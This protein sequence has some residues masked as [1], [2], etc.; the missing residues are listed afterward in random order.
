MIGSGKKVSS[1]GPQG[2][3]LSQAAI[4]A[5]YPWITLRLFDPAAGDQVSM[6]DTLGHASDKRSRDG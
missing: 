2:I 6:T 3:I 5:P 4:I 1:P